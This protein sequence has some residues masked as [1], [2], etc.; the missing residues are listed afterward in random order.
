MD[1]I[2][3]RKRPFQTFGLQLRPSVG[4]PSTVK[5][6]KHQLAQKFTINEA[7]DVLSE[8]RGQTKG[9]GCGVKGASSTK[10]SEW[11]NLNAKN[12]F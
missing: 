4:L 5:I 1:R 12:P 2:I 7:N 11:A 10:R 9:D 6:D 3:V 8:R